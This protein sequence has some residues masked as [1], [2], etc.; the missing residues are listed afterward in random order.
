MNVLE[1]NSLVCFTDKTKRSDA[2]IRDQ[3]RGCEERDK[4]TA[5]AL[6]EKSILPSK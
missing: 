1:H 4:D 2:I 3:T 5:S 6:N